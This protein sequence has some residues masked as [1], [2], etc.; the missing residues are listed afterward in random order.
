MEDAATILTVLSMAAYCAVVVM[1][2]RF[3]IQ[4]SVG[5]RV[6]AALRLLAGALLFALVILWTAE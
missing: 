6:R 4:P 2:W 1:L 3:S 5:A